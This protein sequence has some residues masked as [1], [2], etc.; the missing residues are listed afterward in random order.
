MFCVFCVSACSGSGDVD[1][2]ALPRNNL[3]ILNVRLLWRRLEALAEFPMLAF[4]M[5]PRNSFLASLLIVA[6]N[7]HNLAS[8]AVPQM[9]YSSWS[10]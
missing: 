7:R 4:S 1:V 10:M 9:K 5:L 8:N 6:I 2:V 3:E